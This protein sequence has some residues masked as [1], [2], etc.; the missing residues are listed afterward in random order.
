M[1]IYLITH[2]GIEPS[3]SCPTS[4]RSDC[5]ELC[6]CEIYTPFAGVRRQVQH[7]LNGIQPVKDVGYDNRLGKDRSKNDNDGSICAKGGT[8]AHES[9]S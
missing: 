2:R 8:K 9:S 7:G 1:F 4:V 6:T 3:S 5:E